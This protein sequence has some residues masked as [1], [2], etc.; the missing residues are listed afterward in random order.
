MTF[1]LARPKSQILISQ[2][3]LMR[4]LLGFCKKEIKK[5]K[6]LNHDVKHLQSECISWH[7]ESDT[8]KTEYARQSTVVL[9]FFNF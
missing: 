4:M 6:K 1:P 3:L 2:S 5:K 7:L 9:F 8:K